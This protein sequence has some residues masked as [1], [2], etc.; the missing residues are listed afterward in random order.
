MAVTKSS[1]STRTSRWLIIDS[2]SKC[3]TSIGS[4]IVTTCTSLLL[5]MWSTIPASVVVL[6]DPVGPVTSTSP[7]GSI[8]RLAS[9]AGSPRST[10]G[11]A[12]TL[13]RRNTSPQAP[14]LRKAFTRNRPI[15]EMEK[16]KS[17]SLVRLNCSTRSARMTSVTIRSVSSLVRSRICS[18][19]SVPSIRTRGGEPTLQ[20]RSEP[21]ASTSARSRGS[22]EDVTV[23][24]SARRRRGL[25]LRSSF[26]AAE[27]GAARL[28]TLDA[29]TGR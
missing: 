29:H 13:T 12:P 18:L 15:P 14:L 28:E 7:R 19:R 10:S 27:E 2:L 17:A 1:V 16:A 6:P 4:S 3:S 8:D 22:M 11:I 24:S 5:L 20:C 23:G 26:R 9:T 25:T 21:V